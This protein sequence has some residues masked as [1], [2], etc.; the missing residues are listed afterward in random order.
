MAKKAKLKVPHTKMVESYHALGAARV[1]GYWAQTLNSNFAGCPVLSYFK[2]KYTS[3]HYVIYW[4]GDTHHVGIKDPAGAAWICPVSPIHFAD[5]KLPKLVADA[6][7]GIFPDVRPP[8]SRVKLA[9]SAVIGMKSV[10]KISAVGSKKRKVLSAKKSLR[11]KV[12]LKLR[13]E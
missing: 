4:L 8:V 5:A 9:P 12:K 1:S 7:S 11:R 3:G 2:S 10:D 13:R 6:S